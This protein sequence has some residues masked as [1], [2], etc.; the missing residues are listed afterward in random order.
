MPAK[1]TPFTR[2]TILAHVF[3]SIALYS[4]SEFIAQSLN[5]DAT[6]IWSTLRPA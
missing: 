6:L 3:G 5:G 4:F 2:P 1:F